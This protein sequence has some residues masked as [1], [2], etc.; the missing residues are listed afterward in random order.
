M[1]GRTDRGAE[2]SFSKAAAVGA[3]AGTDGVTQ[4]KITCYNL[5]AKGHY[6]ESCPSTD[7]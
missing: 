1:G 2:V 7:K 3:L 6:Y 4:A 5:N